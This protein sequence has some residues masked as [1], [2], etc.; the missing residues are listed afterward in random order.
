VRR[1]CL[2]PQLC[3][4]LVQ[5]PFRRAPIP[6]A[7]L[8]DEAPLTLAYLSRFSDILLTRGSRPVREL[9]RRTA[10]Y[11]Q[12]GVGE[13]TLAPHQVVWNRMGRELRAAA[14]APPLLATDTC[15]LIPCASA[16]EA[17]WLAA[18]LNSRAIAEALACASDPGRGFASPGAIDLL[19]LPPYDP[20]DARDPEVLLTQDR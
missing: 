14:S 4:L 20:R 1:H 7:R 16:N 19:F 11:A 18:V 6:L 9:A 13:Y 10:F 5:D 15:C 2:E 3:A 17:N 12:Y 8:R